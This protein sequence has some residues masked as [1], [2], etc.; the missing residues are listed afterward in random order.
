MRKNE[1]SLS[2]DHLFEIDKIEYCTRVPVNNNNTIPYQSFCG[3]EKK[4]PIL[5]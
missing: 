5:T 1:K 3:K 4:K 2:S